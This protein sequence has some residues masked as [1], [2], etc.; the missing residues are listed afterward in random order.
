MD[1]KDCGAVWQRKSANGVEYMTGFVEIA[2]SKQEIVMYRNKKDGNE[3]RPDWRIYP[4]EPKGGEAV[5]F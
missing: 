1:K 5:P 2:G 4:S 3:K